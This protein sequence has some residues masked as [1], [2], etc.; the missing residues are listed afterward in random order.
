M[1]VALDVSP[2]LDGRNSEQ[3]WQV[4]GNDVDNGCA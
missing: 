1:G 2:K 4:S 3:C